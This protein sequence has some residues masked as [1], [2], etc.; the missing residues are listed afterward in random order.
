MHLYVLY[1][2]GRIKRITATQIS[3]NERA[4]EENRTKY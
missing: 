3:K 4:N 2:V 1:N